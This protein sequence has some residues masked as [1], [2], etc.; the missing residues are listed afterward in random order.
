M[1]RV[2]LRLITRQSTRINHSYRG[3]CKAAIHDN[4]HAQLNS[5]QLNVDDRHPVADPW[6]R[7]E[8]SF[9]NPSIT[10]LRLQ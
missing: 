2:L 5:T 9:R 7:P 1:V 10:E 3:R 8:R 6:L 4:E